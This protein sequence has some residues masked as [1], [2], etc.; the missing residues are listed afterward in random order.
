[1]T[2][3]TRAA[4]ADH[5]AVDAG[6]LDAQRTSTWRLKPTEGPLGRG[7][8][9]FTYLE[10]LSMSIAT[11]FFD[12]LGKADVS[13][14][15]DLTTPDFT[16]TVAGKPDQF[17]LAGTYDRDGYIDMLGRV[18]GFLPAGPQVQVTSVTADSHHEVI[19]A[20]VTAVSAAGTRY[21]N[22]LV[23]VFDLQGDK[24][25]AV[26]EYLDTIHASEIFVA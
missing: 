15:L 2:T 25:Q 11:D 22:A 4:A 9:L 24:I 10:E 1:M 5:V 18:G 16:W 21:D 8:S 23:Y 26:R 3:Y 14:A 20:H 13:G 19:E 17:A 6:A 7:A 12:R